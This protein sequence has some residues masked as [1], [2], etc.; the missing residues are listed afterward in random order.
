[1]IAQRTI[2]ARA[3][4]ELL[5]LALLWGAS[6]LSIRIALGEV[7]PLWSVA[8]RVGLGAAALL[9]WLAVRGIALPRGRVW[10]ALGIMGILNNAI[11]FSLMAWAQLHIETG[12]TGILN[13]ATA[14]FGVVVAAIAF[15]DERL[16]ARR[17]LGVA[18]GFAGVATAVGWSALAAFDP[19]SHAQVAVIAGTVSYAVAG[20]F[21]RARLGDLRPESAAAGMLV[22]STLAMIPLAFAVDGAPR[23]DL[24]PSTWLAMAYYG[25]GSTATAYL[26]YYRVLRMA[27]AGNLMLV[28]LLVAPVSIVLGALVLDEDLAPRAYAGFVLLALGLAILDGRLFARA[29]GNGSG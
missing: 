15:A 6:F 9:A 7:T 14:I 11:P 3:W 21:A 23:L 22:A 28:T 4:A 8:W 19:R 5:L 20:A 17:A 18:L 24:V 26:L 29:R 2:P 25:I 12:L 16:T 10:L 27:G 1:M 13:A